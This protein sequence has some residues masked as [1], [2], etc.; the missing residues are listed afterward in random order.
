MAVIYYLVI[1]P[2]GLIMRACGR[3][4][5]HR[6]FDRAVRKLLAG[7]PPR[8]PKGSLFSAVLRQVEAMTQDKQQQPS[9][10][11]EE[12]F[13][14]EAEQHQPGLLAEFLD[15]LLHNKK[16]WLTP[17]ILTLLLIGVLVVLSGTAVASFIYT[18][19]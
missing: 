4:P 6:R 15:F 9:A 2:I 8:G 10:P 18:L 14:A 11:E 1:T 7:P 17:I 13:A 3:D 16:W 5:M 12:E 19:W